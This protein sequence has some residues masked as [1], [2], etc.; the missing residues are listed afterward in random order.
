M[1]ATWFRD[2][3]IGKPRFEVPWDE[4]LRAGLRVKDTPGH[5]GHSW[6]FID[7]TPLDC[8][9]PIRRYY[10]NSTPRSEGNEASRIRRFIRRHLHAEE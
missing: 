8:G 7:C 3:H 9:D 10:V 6:G 1:I 4:A 2:G 5:H